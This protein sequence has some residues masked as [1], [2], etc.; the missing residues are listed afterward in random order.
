MPNPNSVLPQP[1]SPPF[2]KQFRGQHDFLHHEAE[3][4]PSHQTDPREVRIPTPMELAERAQGK[5]NSRIRQL[6]KQGFY[7]EDTSEQRSVG[8]HRQYGIDHNALTVAVPS[9]QL[10]L[11]SK[12]LQQPGAPNYQPGSSTII[13]TAEIPGVNTWPHRRDQIMHTNAGM[14]AF[15]NNTK[16]QTA[17]QN[18]VSRRQQPQNLLGKIAL[19]FRLIVPSEKHLPPSLERHAR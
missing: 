4:P 11:E 2:Q 8:N 17:T 10:L 15:W 16:N 18:E 1:D 13:E 12:K 5:E 3:V 7:T 19:K 9:A 14:A 6:A